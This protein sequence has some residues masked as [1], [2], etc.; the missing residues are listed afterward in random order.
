MLLACCWGWEPPS[1]FDTSKAGS[2]A[3][4]FPFSCI[5]AMSSMVRVVGCKGCPRDRLSSW[6]DA[7]PNSYWVASVQHAIAIKILIAVRVLF[8]PSTARCMVQVIS[9]FAHPH[10][11]LVICAVCSD[12]NSGK[13]WF[14]LYVL[15]MVMAGLAQR[16]SRPA[17]FREGGSDLMFPR[18]RR[19]C[20]CDVLHTV[21]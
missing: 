6:L 5:P 8:S 10:L 3:F 13:G 4:F 18:W 15:G 14:S 1:P 21:N 17:L 16:V 12:G 19:H 11:L 20:W 2:T 7:E 9:P